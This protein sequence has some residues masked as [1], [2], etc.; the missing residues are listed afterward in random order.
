LEPAALPP[1]A[2]AALHAGLAGERL[3]PSYA[4]FVLRHVAADDATWRWCCGSSCDPCV[5]RLGRVVD[6]VRHALCPRGTGNAGT[7]LPGAPDPA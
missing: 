1:D 6:R 3:D 4:T 7:G 2:T 5:Q